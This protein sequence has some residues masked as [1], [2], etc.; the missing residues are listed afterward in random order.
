M[1]CRCMTVN[2]RAPADVKLLGFYDIRRA[3]VHS[4][5][6]RTIVIKVPHEDDECKSGYAV[7]D[8]AV[9]ATKDAAQCFDVANENAT[10]AMGFDTGT[11]FALSGSFDRS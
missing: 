11:F 10:T 7:L 5:A 4:L 2:R 6:L 1:L 8:K 9:Y 3:P